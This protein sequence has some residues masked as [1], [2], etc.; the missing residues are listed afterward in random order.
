[1]IYLGSEHW[2]GA[3]NSGNISLFII[4]IRTQCSGLQYFLSLAA[5]PRP[6]HRSENMCETNGENNNNLFDVY[7]PKPNPLSLLNVE[8]NFS[9][10]LI[11]MW[12]QHVPDCRFL[13]PT[14]SVWDLKFSSNEQISY[15]EFLI[16]SISILF[17]LF[18]LI[19]E[20]VKVK[21]FLR[22]VAIVLTLKSNPQKMR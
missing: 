1:M 8:F 7:F 5:P 6:S 22:K 18:D 21:K 15:Y 12:A 11:Q 17:Q 20:I 19:L 16:Y 13:M 9:H 10:V 3:T 2:V 4:V 14:M